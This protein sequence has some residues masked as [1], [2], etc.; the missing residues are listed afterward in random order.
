MFS[1]FLGLSIFILPGLINA[2]YL[3]LNLFAG[4]VVVVVTICC[5]FK[6]LAKSASTFALHIF[7]QNV[8]CSA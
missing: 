4:V 5:E 6:S 1:S 2:H 3:Y 8:D 7:C